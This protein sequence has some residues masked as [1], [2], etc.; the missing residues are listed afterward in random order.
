MNKEARKVNMKGFLLLLHELGLDA[1]A[2]RVDGWMV[3][4]GV[5]VLNLRS[6][7]CE[8]PTQG[9]SFCAYLEGSNVVRNWTVRSK[10]TCSCLNHTHEIASPSAMA[11]SVFAA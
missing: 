7:S 6:R 10:K 8:I 1:D 4:I 9:N 2:V 5:A 11:I 3:I